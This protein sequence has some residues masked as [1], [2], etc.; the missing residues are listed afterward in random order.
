MEKKKKRIPFIVIAVLVIMASMLMIC[1]CRKADSSKGSVE[2][3]TEKTE[4]RYEI[5]AMISEGKETTAEDLALLQSKGLSCT[6]VLRP[7]GTGVL[8]LFG[9]KTNLTWDEKNIS[10]GTKNMPYT[11]KDD[12]LTLT[13]GN[14]S[15]TFQNTDESEDAK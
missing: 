13:D 5:I 2:Q 6:I 7:D 1:S 3:K 10:T 12:Q 14:S 8:D 15:L 11:R 9:E 4:E